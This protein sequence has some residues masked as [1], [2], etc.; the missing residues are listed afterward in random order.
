MDCITLAQ[1][2]WTRRCFALSTFQRP[3]QVSHNHAIAS[4]DTLPSASPE[5]RRRSTMRAFWA[6]GWLNFPIA[7]FFVG[8]RGTRWLQTTFAWRNWSDSTLSGR[9]LSYPLEYVGFKRWFCQTRSS[10]MLRS[11]DMPKWAPLFGMQITSLA[12]GRYWTVVTSSFTHISTG[13]LAGN[14]LSLW[15]FAPICADIPGLSWPHVLVITLAASLSSSLASIV[16][17]VYFPSIS[18]PWV[19]SQNTALGFSG[20][21]MAF[22][23]LAAASSPRRSMTGLLPIAVPCWT[24]CGILM[25]I[26]IPGA[27]HTMG[28]VRRAPWASKM[29]QSGHLAHLAGLVTG[30]LYY[31]LLL[32]PRTSVEASHGATEDPTG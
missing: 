28:F 25:L 5:A 12:N 24:A 9:L 26:D 1:H 11:L 8:L 10:S 29:G 27:L 18:N 30:A 22:V 23:G 7:S 3:L 19:A 32:R 16:Q 4:Y 6:V 15:Q 2:D 21:N 14:M 31:W 20:I 13:H 17:L